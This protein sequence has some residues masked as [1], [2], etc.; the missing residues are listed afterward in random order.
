VCR[1]TAS[2]CIYAKAN[3]TYSEIKSPWPEHLTDGG[4]ASAEKLL[5]A[6]K[7]ISMAADAE[8]SAAFAWK[9]LAGAKKY[10]TSFSGDFS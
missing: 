9:I 2:K 1:Q 7:N 3:G 5:R 8:T 6:K 10:F 4:V